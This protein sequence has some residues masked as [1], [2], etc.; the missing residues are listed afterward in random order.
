MNKMNPTIKRKWIKALRSEKNVTDRL[1]DFAVSVMSAP[2]HWRSLVR[3]NVSCGCR[4]LEDCHDASLIVGSWLTSCGPWVGDAVDPSE[5]QNLAFLIAQARLDGGPCG[6]LWLIGKRIQQAA[7][8]F[9]RP[10]I[11]AEFARLVEERDP[12]PYD[13]SERVLDDMHRAADVRE[14]V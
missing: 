1:A 7:I 13:D 5:D 6:P 11:D 2:D 3:T 8:E 9:A 10:A 12:R 4:S 14:A